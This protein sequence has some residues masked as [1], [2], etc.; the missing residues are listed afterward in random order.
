VVLADDAGRQRHAA[1]DTRSRDAEHGSDASRT[2][3]KRST[4]SQHTS[5]RACTALGTGGGNHGAQAVEEI[6]A[7]AVAHEQTAPLDAARH[8]VLQ[9]MRGIQT[10]AQGQEDMEGSNIGNASTACMRRSQRRCVD[11][12]AYDA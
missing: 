11:V 3:P 6:L 7:V 5:A 1:Q 10:R 2:K 9:S 4:A 8:D 12:L